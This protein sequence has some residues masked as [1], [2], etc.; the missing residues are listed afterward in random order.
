M[1][2]FGTQNYGAAND[3]EISWGKAKASISGHAKGLSF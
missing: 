1:A 2:G 3:N